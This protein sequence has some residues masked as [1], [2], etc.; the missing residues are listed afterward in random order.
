MRLSL[1]P[2]YLETK[3]DI[4]LRNMTLSPG[5][6]VNLEG[7]GRVQTPL[8]FFTKPAKGWRVTRE[9]P[10]SVWSFHLFR[11]SAGPFRDTT[12]PKAPPGTGTGGTLTRRRA[13]AHQW[14]CSRPVLS[15]PDSPLATAAAPGGPVCTPPQRGATPRDPRAG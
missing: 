13:P 14:G 8:L 11:D 10:L 1:F 3:N 6:N 5:R 7:M 15:C 4:P 9:Q 2:S 12:V